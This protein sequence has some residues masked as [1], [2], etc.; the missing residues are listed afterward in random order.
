MEG[1]YHCKGFRVHHNANSSI[2]LHD[3]YIALTL[4]KL[5]RDGSEKGN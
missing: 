3:K 2:N 5:K 1:V 4:G